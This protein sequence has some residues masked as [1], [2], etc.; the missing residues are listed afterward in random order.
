MTISMYQ[1]SV[2]RLINVLKNLDKILDKTQEHIEAKKIDAA[3][4]IDW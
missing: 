4:I 1:A 2:P 3:C